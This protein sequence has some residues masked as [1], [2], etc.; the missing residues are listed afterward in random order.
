MDLLRVASDWSFT[1]DGLVGTCRSAPTA[2]L[3]ARWVLKSVILDGREVLDDRLWFEP[4]RHYEN[5]QIVVTDRRSQVR[6]RVSE[7]DGTPTGEYVAVA[8]L[9]EVSLQ[10]YLLSDLMK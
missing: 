1:I 10:R 2:P 3:T 5:V 7:V 9:I 4:G 8:F 6:V